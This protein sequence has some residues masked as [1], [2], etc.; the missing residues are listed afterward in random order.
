M[1]NTDKLLRAFIDASG[2]E[3]E[4][5][6]DY[7]ERKLTKTQARHHFTVKHFGYTPTHQLETKLGGMGQGEYLIDD[8]GNYTERLVKPIINYKVT[9]KKES[10]SGHGVVIPMRVYDELVDFLQAN[11]GTSS[12]ELPH[13]TAWALYNEKT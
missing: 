1:N 7:Q 5:T 2:F 6:R 9:K 3:V 10:N 8:K 11:S 12:D 13:V 4:I